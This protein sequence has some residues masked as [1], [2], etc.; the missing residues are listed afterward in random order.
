LSV[1]NKT[2]LEEV[3]TAWRAGCL[4]ED[5]GLLSGHVPPLFG[6]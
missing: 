1:W 6:S 4:D 3:C 2:L 5:V